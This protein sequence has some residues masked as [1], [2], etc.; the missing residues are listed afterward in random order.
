MLWMLGEDVSNDFSPPG[1]YHRARWMAKGIY[2][3]KIY[4]FRH[5]FRLNKRETESLRRICLF[6]CTIYANYWFCAPDTAS[7]PMNDL[8]MLHLI[9]D[10]QD[11]DAKVAGIVEKKMR[12]HLWYLSEDLA[13]LPLFG[14]DVSIETKKSV[15]KALAKEPCANDVR[16]LAPNKITSFKGLSVADFVTSRSLNLFSAFSLSQQFLEEDVT[17]WSSSED[18]LA[19]C[20]IIH[21]VKVVNDCA[22]RAVKLATD[23]NEI[24]TKSDEQRQLLY[25]VV[26]HHR[27]LVATDA[28]KQQLV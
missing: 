9:A 24:L 11:I 19:A 26:E 18:Y 14:N 6:V 15:V 22:E 5:Q 21:A 27:K 16:R 28:A 2:C 10:Y 4:G 7:A 1:A 20:K 3:L 8:A 13:A 23:F 12:L 25:Q 17:T